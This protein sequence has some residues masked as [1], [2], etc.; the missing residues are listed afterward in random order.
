[1]NC[2]FALHVDVGVM[3][4]SP[5]LPH[6]KPEATVTGMDNFKNLCLSVAEIIT[7]DV[8]CNDKELK[9]VDFSVFPAL[10][11]LEIGH[12]CFKYTEEV[13]IIGMKALERVTIGRSSFAEYL[14]SRDAKGGF[15]LSDCERV[16]ELKIGS[17]SFSEYAVCEIR[18]DPLLEKIEVGERNYTY[19]EL[20]KGSKTHV[21]FLETIGVN[22]KGI[23][24]NIQDKTDP[25]S[26]LLQ[27]C[28]RL[29]YVD[30]RHDCFMDDPF[31]DC[32]RVVFESDWL[33]VRMRNRLARTDI[34][35]DIQQCV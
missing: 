29:V 30:V 16:K 21:S 15:Y 5:Y 24:S 31:H 1:M 35:S 7:D 13:R 26:T 11:R 32:S 6:H 2:V 28:L 9:S 10:Q 3:N 4:D 25:K 33:E 8:C 20:I 23:P 17:F 22:V 19:L 18:N 14:P 27:L 12:D 34:H